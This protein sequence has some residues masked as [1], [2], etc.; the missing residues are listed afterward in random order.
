MTLPYKVYLCFLNCR[1]NDTGRVREVKITDQLRANWLSA[2]RT[3][4]L[5]FDIVYAGEYN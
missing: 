5:E 2:L 4:K 3:G 1:K